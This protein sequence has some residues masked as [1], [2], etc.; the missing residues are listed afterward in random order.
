MLL[1]A[2]PAVVGITALIWTFRRPQDLA[3]WMLILCSSFPFITKGYLLAYGERSFAFRVEYA[4][5][6]M[7]IG[8]VVLKGHKAMLGYRSRLSVRILTM[9]ALHLLAVPLSLSWDAPVGFGVM[10]KMLETYIFVDLRE[11]DDSKP[12]D[13]SSF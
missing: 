1:S 7:G 9:V 12:I 3:I 10:L 11:A 4:L 13:C 6:F 2:L 8:W 5:V